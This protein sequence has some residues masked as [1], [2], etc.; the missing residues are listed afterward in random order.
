MEVNY[1]D[2]VNVVVVQEADSAASCDVTG[3]LNRAS[4]T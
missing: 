4:A 3:V 1:G 2:Q